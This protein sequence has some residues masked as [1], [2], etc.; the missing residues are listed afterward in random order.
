[1]NVFFFKKAKRP[2]AVNACGLFF[3]S[4]GSP[5]L[6]AHPILDSS[7]SSTGRIVHKSSTLGAKPASLRVVS[8]DDMIFRFT[9]TM[10]SDEVVSLC[11]VARLTLALLAKSVMVGTRRRLEAGFSSSP[12]LKRKR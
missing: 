3:A 10:L 12:A 8:T 1:M 2:Q 11:M 7:S 4:L 9:L 5:R 6:L